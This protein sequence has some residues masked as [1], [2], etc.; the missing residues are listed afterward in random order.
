MKLVHDGVKPFDCENCGKSFGTKEILNRHIQKVHENIENKKKKK[1]STKVKIKMKKQDFSNS[2][3]SSENND[4]NIQDAI[5]E[6]IHEE[7]LE[8]NVNIKEEPWD[9]NDT[10]VLNFPAFSGPVKN[11]PSDDIFY[12][13]YGDPLA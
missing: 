9:Q 4:S 8:P 10:D 3:L 12:N 1:K 6:D 2:H 11:E 13:D 7:L 5:Y